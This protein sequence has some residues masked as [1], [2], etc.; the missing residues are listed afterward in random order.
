MSY[1]SYTWIPNLHS[2][3]LVP[4]NSCPIPLLSAQLREHQ[5]D[6]P[7][8]FTLEFISPPRHSIFRG[9]DGIRSHDGRDRIYSV[10]IRAAGSN[11]S[12]TA[13]QVFVS[14]LFDDWSMEFVNAM[15]VPS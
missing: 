12:A 1:S 15:F 13:A 2:D 4:R 8:L 7:M 3:I 10:R 11:R 14:S 9:E 6:T 5:A